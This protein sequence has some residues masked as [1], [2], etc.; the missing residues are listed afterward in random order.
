MKLAVLVL[1]ISAVAAL[2]LTPANFDKE[3]AGKTVFLKFFAPWCGHCKS[4]KPAWD[5]LMKEYADHKSILVA[6]VDCTAGG[7]PL[8]DAQGVKGFPTLKHGDP[9]SLEAYEGG[10]DAADLKKF[11]SG[12]KPSC[13]IANLALCDAEGKNKIEAVMA[14]SDAAIDTFIESGEKKMKDAEATFDSELE[15]LQATYKEL[16]ATKEATLAEVKE[17]GLGLYKSVKA[18]KAKDVVGKEEL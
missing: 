18:H 8:C 17:S 2:E 3:T 1:V 16:M 9:S 14:L 6:D 12:L 11:A 13:S 7:K 4:M 10:R 5:A 15:K